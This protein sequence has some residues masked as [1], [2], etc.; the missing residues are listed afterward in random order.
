MI[1]TM[2]LNGTDENPFHKMG[3]TQ[4]PFP[5]IAKAE[6]MPQMH[7]INEL[8]AN[9]IKDVDDLRARMK[10]LFTDEFIEGCVARFKKGEYVEFEVS[11]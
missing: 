3:L 9:P 8:A 11:F 2:R 4:N 7:A 1:F 5:Q 6:Y 10:D